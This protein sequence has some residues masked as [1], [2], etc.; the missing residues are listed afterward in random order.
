MRAEQF[1]Q[2]KADV[3]KILGDSLVGEVGPDKGQFA[4]CTSEP[5]QGENV[6]AKSIDAIMEAKVKYPDLARWPVMPFGVKGRIIYVIAGLR[7]G[8][9]NDH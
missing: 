6:K 4:F 2:F 5:D 8:E 1:E 7:R 3:R 9:S